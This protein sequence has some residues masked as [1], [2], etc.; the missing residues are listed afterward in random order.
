MRDTLEHLVVGTLR[1]PDFNKFLYILNQ[2]DNAAREDNPEEVFAAWQ[3]ALAQKGLTAGRFYQ[4]Y[5][6]ASAA[7]IE[8]EHLR[9]RF[10]A[11]R[12]QDM[13]AILDRVRQLEVERS[14]R[15]AGSLEQTAE[16]I[17]DHL[18]P[19][20][21][22][23][24]RAWGRRVLWLDA[25]VFGGLAVLA[26][27]LASTYD[28]WNELTAWRAA[29]VANPVAG[30]VAVAAVA[31]GA[32]LLHRALRRV[33][34]RGVQRQIERDASLG[35]HAPR[36]ARAFALNVKSWWP[37]LAARPLG[38]TGGVRRRLDGVL[39]EAHATIQQF[40]DRYADPSGSSRVEGSAAN[41]AAQELMPD[42]ATPDSAAAPAE[43][44]APPPPAHGARRLAIWRDRS[45]G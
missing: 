27:V 44:S 3:R 15:V 35:E 28:V 14:Y 25:L 13:S 6:P 24:R 20:L 21:A 29:F 33:A 18:V 12:E 2:I 38:W 41:G 39:S 9:R 32:W 16:H 36:V 7:P 11:K 34:A 37:V 22:A 43:Q 31:V 45:A 23:A 30:W 10:E 1:R 8:D 26:A 42:S 4:I 17:R 40:N 19:R 5:D